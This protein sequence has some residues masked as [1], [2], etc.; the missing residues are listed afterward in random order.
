MDL[1]TLSVSIIVPAYNAEQYIAEAIQ[2]VLNQTFQ[3][4]ELLVIDDGSRDNT[5]KIVKSFFDPRII[6]IQQENGGVSSARNKGL[7][8]VK[9][10]YITFLDADDILPPKSLEVRVN[11]LETNDYV[12]LLDGKAEVKDLTMQKSLRIYNPTYQGM[13]L[14]R[15]IRL[16]AQVYFTCHYMF[17]KK[18]LGNTRFEEHMTHLEDILFFIELSS[19]QEVQYAYVKETVFWYRVGHTSA[20]SNI[21]G[22]EKGYLSLIQKVN[23]FN[24]ISFSQ[25]IF[26]R[27]KIIRILF[28]TW[29]KEKK[30]DRAF[31]AI[32]QV[33]LLS[34]KWKFI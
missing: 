24:N 33:M 15:L 30:I 31:K 4:W 14:P 8:G 25:H 22:L 18:I 32:F 23:E 19:I 12:D 9:G 16:D 17:R 10:K 5:A 20:M 13:L 1:S 7:E 34:K 6:L 3:D 27:S 21:D 26:L 29:L 11:Y 28:L 2:S